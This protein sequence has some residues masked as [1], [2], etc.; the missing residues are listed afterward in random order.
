M[1]RLYGLIGY[2]LSHSF[3]PGYFAEKFM[4]EGIRDAEY[5]AFPLERI[6]E[7]PALLEREPRLLG[8]NVT[9]P[10]KESA[11]GY[12]QALSPEAEE[13]G[14]VNT[15]QYGIDKVTGH[16]TDWLG[17]LQSFEPLWKSWRK[18]PEGAEAPLGALVLGTGGSSRA[19]HYALKRLGYTTRSVSR[20][21]G[22]GVDYTYPQLDA[23]VLRDYPVLVNCTPLGMFPEVLTRPE[24]PYT[25]LGPGN[26]L[27]DLIYNPD[28]TIFLI[29]GEQQGAAT[30]NGLGMLYGQAEAAWTIWNPSNGD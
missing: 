25:S 22:P 13:I 30:G 18:K 17:F 2:P 14:A 9:I 26:L 27:F 21:E 10:Y 11:M 3:S 1:K 16:N 7:L 23:Q 5:R 8:L 4:R 12:V 24:I 29:K 28:K 15:I 19:V 20:R 6:E